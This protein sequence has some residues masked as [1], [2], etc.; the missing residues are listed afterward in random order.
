[1]PCSE[2]LGA[3]DADGGSGGGSWSESGWTAGRGMREA[4]EDREDYQRGDERR[5]RANREEET[6]AEDP[7]VVSDHHA[8][9][10]DD[11]RQPV[12][13]DGHD[14]AP[15]DQWAAV[16]AALHEAEHDVQSEL[17]GRPD[18]E[19]QRKDV[20]HV[21][22]QSDERHQADRPQQAHREGYEREGGFAHPP[23]HQ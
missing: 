19:G 2:R 14:R 22:L 15:R 3:G 10:T 8:A 4:E 18:D 13:E 23:Q 9:E 6:E 12:E 21:E 5:R 1:M 20:A 7:A 17:G 11:G 16:V